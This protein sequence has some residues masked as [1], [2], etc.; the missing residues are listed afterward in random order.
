ME[1]NGKKKIII[2]IINVG[3]KKLL[4]CREP[5]VGD[6]ARQGPLHALLETGLGQLRPRQR[7]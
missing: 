5:H 6:I 3:E 4:P 7:P 2:I 1:N